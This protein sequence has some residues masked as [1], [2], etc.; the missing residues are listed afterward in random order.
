M[1]D[2][3]IIYGSTTGN[4]EAAAQKIAA[5]LGANATSIA[6]AK[7][8]DFEAPLILLGCS[9][10]GSGELQD[11]WISGIALLDTLDL[12]GKR[13]GFFGTGDQDTFSDTFVDALGILC[14]KALERGATL[15]GQTLPEGYAFTASRALRDGQLCGL[16]LDDNEDHEVSE[17]RL[18]EWAAQFK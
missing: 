7:P 14:E 1:P 9:T 3:A 13:V 10:W 5:L 8:A 11:D 16:A 12:T 4:T 6:Q 2:I 17:N 18:T 15:T